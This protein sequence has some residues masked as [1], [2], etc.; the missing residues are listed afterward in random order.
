MRASRPQNLLASA[1]ASLVLALGLFWAWNAFTDSDLET[2]EE[3]DVEIPPTWLEGDPPSTPPAP[4]A[5][6]PPPKPVPQA[7]GDKPEPPPERVRP[8]AQPPEDDE[9]D[10]PPE[11]PPGGDGRETPPA[12]PAFHMDAFR[13]K[14]LRGVARTSARATEQ[15]LVE[16]GDAWIG[17]PATYV[18]GLANAPRVGGYVALLTEA[19]R[20][21]VRV[22]E[23]YIDRFELRNHQYL[24]FLNA[25]ARI[26]YNTSDHD[27][28]TLSEIVAYLIPERPGNVDVH[29]VA[30]QLF[31]ANR[32]ALVTAWKDLVVRNRDQVIDLER[33]YERIRDRVVPRSLRLVFY[34]RAPPGTWPGAD[35][36]ARRGDHPVRDISL[37]EATAYALHVGRHIPTEIQWEYAARGPTGLDYPWDQ[38]GKDFKFHV[39]GGIQLERGA[40]PET[41]PATHFPGG[42]SWIGCFNMLGNVSEWTSSYNDPYPDGVRDPTLP[43]GP[44]LVVR[45]GSARDQSRWDLRSALRGWRADDPDGTPRPNQRRLWTG[46]RTARFREP[47]QSRLP[48]MH[49]RAR[50]RLP[51]AREVLEPLIFEGWAGEQTQVFERVAGEDPRL[52]P[53]SGVK[54]LVAQPLRLLTVRN[55]ADGRYTANPDDTL[56][57]PAAVLLASQTAPVLIG[58][59][60][61]DL[62][63][64]DLWSYFNGG[65]RF[66]PGGPPSRLRRVDARPGTYFVALVNGLTALVRTDRDEV[67]F[68]SNRPPPTGV[69]NVLEQKFRA[70]APR[71]PQVVLGFDRKSSANLELKVPVHAT[72]TPGFAVLLRIKLRVDAREVGFVRSWAHGRFVK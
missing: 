69:F 27:A 54:S 17:S 34:D 33:T 53:R 29:A 65:P 66:R 30:R 48:T 31:Y 7:P 60:H 32:L 68:I 23:F 39:N 21:R 62:H 16:E 37:D 46:I 5:T 3:I 6:N 25:T 59:L 11:F 40:E 55:A 14:L 8:D 43:A 57:D 63:L 61:V 72:G 38:R 45:G 49:Y 50:Q 52:K 2:G 44:V 18:R 10:L 1:V 71:R 56:S 64:T 28:R 20:H 24:Q 70:G 35:Y 4:V 13:T 51:L 42:T 47:A 36:A 58:V 12:A 19:P 67:Y 9:P 26:I 41:K 22:P 15:V